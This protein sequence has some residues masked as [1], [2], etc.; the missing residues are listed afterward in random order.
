M[1]TMP[2]LKLTMTSSDWFRHPAFHL[3]GANEI[4]NCIKFEFEGPDFAAI[5]DK[6]SHLDF[7]TIIRALRFIIDFLRTI[8]GPQGNGIAKVFD[9]KLPLIDRSLSELIDIAGKVAEKLDEIASNPVGA[10]QD[11]PAWSAVPS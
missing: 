2:R 4:Q 1:R 11:F 7:A 5:V 8:D 10:V 9:T 3:C 6:F